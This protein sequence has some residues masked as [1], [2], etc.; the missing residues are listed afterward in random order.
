MCLLGEYEYIDVIMEETRLI[1][2]IDF[3]SEFEM[4]R[5]T[6][7]YKAVIQS[8]PYIF[9]GKTERLSEIVSMVSE[10]AKRNIKKKG[11]HFPPW[12]K[13]EYM[14]AKWLSSY[15]RTKQTGSLVKVNDDVLVSGEK[16]V[17]PPESEADSGE[18]KLKLE[19][20]ATSW[21]PPTAKAKV[22]IVTGLA[23]LLKDKQ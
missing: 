16:M 23:L 20:A 22:A 9:V 13:T 1:V 6:G 11:M 14:L 3:R 15:T 21:R 4:A 12:R 18:E 2:D 17:S 19:A 7:N 5:S 8:L 10:A